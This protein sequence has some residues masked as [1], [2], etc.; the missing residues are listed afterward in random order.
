MYSGDYEPVP[1]TPSKPAVRSDDRSGPEAEPETVPVEEHPPCVEL[2][3]RRD[4][5]V[6]ASKAGPQP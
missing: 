2:R 3:V 5:I 6:R 4:A 1:R